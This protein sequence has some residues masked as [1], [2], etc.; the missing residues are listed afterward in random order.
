[1]PEHVLYETHKGWVEV[2]LNQPATRNAITGPLAVELAEAIQKANADQS[3][4]LILLRGAD[5]SFCSGLNL[6]EFNKQ[7]PPPW[8]KNFQSYWRDVHTALYLSSKPIVAAVERFAI[9]GGAALALAAD[10]LIVGEDS[11]V[12]VGEV[13]Q[14]LSAPYNLAWLHLRQSDSVI[15]QLTLTG[16]RFTGSELHRLGVAFAA[17]PTKEVVQKATTLCEEL[18]AYPDG[19]LQG[20][21]SIS[22]SYRTHSAD[23]WFQIA[24]SSASRRHGSIPI[25]K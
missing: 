4:Q 3:V 13:K 8:L 21:K 25:L 23:E 14:G 19:A 1:M 9:N 18:S 17:P 11:F 20:I 12:Q 24:S 16:N 10:I 2:I 7:P 22:Q 5:G 6:K 15:A